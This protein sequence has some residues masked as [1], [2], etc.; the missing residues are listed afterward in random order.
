MGAESPASI[1]GKKSQAIAGK[2]LPIYVQSLWNDSILGFDIYLYN[3]QEMILYRA[4]DIQFTAKM[5]KALQESGVRH[6]YIKVENRKEYQ[7]YIQTHITKILKDPALDDFT[8]SSIVYD[9]TKEV[10]KEALSNPTTGENIKHCQAMVESTALYIL[11]GKNAFHN[12]LRI[13]SFDYSIYTH[14]VNV[15]TFSLA[16]AN[17]AGINTTKELHEIGTGALLHDVGKIKVPE[18]I[19]NKVGSLD[20]KEWES[21]RKHPRW[22]VEIIRETDL[23]PEVSYVPI[24]QH[25]ER[26]N[27]SGYPD[28]ISGKELHPFSNI[29]AIADMFDAMTTERAYRKAVSGYNALKAMYDGKNKL[30]LK[31]LEQFT[32]LLGPSH[33]A[34]L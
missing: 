16:L 30:D 13:M 3:G 24:R 1:K 33:I 4:A 5:R 20:Q 2:F 8:K 7:K 27:G 18:S 12:M 28:G 6:L 11:E 15:C 19:L 32:K 17:A 9:N 25:H 31:L 14:S 10:I 21:I 34:H 26:K 29:V 23:I 22:G